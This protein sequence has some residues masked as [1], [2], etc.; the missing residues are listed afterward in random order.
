MLFLTGMGFGLQSAEAGSSP[1]PDILV[2]QAATITPSPTPIQFS[3]EVIRE[4]RPVG[5]I[6]GTLIILFIVAAGTIPSLIKFA[7]ADSQ[8]TK[9]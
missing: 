5:I 2:Q 7:R 8:T 9:K 4:G 6:V 3:Q 1:N